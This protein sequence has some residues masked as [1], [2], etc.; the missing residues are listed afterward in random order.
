M[1]RLFETIKI[2]DGNPCNLGLHDVRMNRSRQMLY[3]LNDELRLSEYIRVPEE[4]RSGVFRCRV[5]YGHDV[6]STE[7]N[8]Y[9]PAAIKTLKLVHANTLTYDFK[10]LDR[11]SLTGL[12]NRDEADDILIIKNW[13]V[14]DSS[15]ANIVFTDGQKW[16]TPDTPLLCGTMRERLLLDGVIEAERIT[17]DDL[18]RFTHFRLINAMLGFCAP[19]LPAKNIIR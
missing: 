10:Y 19:L 13:C 7:F 2:A 14:T 16:V 12:I 4:C 17:V 1:C 18:G 8:P 11:S 5:V 3:G 15:Y 9:S 6:V